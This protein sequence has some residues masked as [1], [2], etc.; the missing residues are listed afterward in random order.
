V[1]A[2]GESNRLAGDGVSIVRWWRKIGLAV[3]ATAITAGLALAQDSFPMRPITLIVPFP[4]G[5]NNTIIARI[6]AEKMSEALGKQIVVDNR[7]GAGGTLASRAVAQSTPD[8]YT[9]L[10][11]FSGTLAIA[12]S[13]YPNAG[14]DVR[15]DFAP[16]G[17]VATAPST[18]IV[19]PSF[20]VTSVAELVAKAK[21]NPGK[22][23]FASSGT[24][25]VSHLAS[26]LF[27]HMAGLK[28]THI[29]Y[30]G[31]GPAMT[32]VLGGHVPMIVVPI[33]VAH[34]NVRSGLLRALAVT[35]TTRSSVL[36]EVPTMAE[37]GLPGYEA[38]A[39]YGIVAPA[40]TPRPII[41]RLTKEL[42]AALASEEVRKRLETD[43]AEPLPSTPEEYAADIDRE[44][45]MWSKLIKA[46]GIKAE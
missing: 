20:G 37:A 6:V 24:S 8:G 16:V 19:H 36:A 7:A 39:R 2:G 25:T 46:A 13:L 40:G 42:R 32:D 9:L 29:P 28:M 17:R 44:E 30:K 35:S 15:K 18:L 41:E 45:T 11:G 12:P 5:G 14:Y 34:G 21:A 10:W 22:F 23:N 1:V 33:P 31:T 38:V 43:G 4:P 3:V 26:E 27:V